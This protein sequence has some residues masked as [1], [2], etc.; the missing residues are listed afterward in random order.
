MSWDPFGIEGLGC[1]EVYV[2]E[3][4]ANA[5]GQLSTRNA[6]PGLTAIGAKQAAAVPGALQGEQ[7]FASTLTRTQLTA[8]ARS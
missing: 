7:V 1:A 6:G 4:P 5:L 3:T 2:V 8:T